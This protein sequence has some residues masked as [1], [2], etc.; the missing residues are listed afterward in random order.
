MKRLV[1]AFVI[2][3]AG[4][5]SLAACASPAASFRNGAAVGRA[6]AS[7]LAQ[8]PSNLHEARADCVTQ[9][10]ISGPPGSNRAKWIAGCVGGIRQIAHS[11]GVTLH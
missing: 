9:W 8:L 6:Y 11:E 5:L 3:V 4:S 7:T 10:S 2:G 1:A